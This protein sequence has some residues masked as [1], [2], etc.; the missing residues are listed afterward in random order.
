[1]VCN[2]LFDIGATMGERL[3]Y[4]ASVGFV[5]AVA[6]LLYRGAERLNRNPGKW[7][8]AGSMTVIV[9][10]SAIKTIS[11]NLDWKNDE[12]LFF[13]DVKV[14]PNSFLV[15][16]NVATMLVNKAEFEKDEQAK[17]LDLQ[18][19]LKLFTKVI[20]MQEHY[21]LGYM[22]RSVAYYKLGMTDS[23][24]AD[25]DTVRAIYY[26]H[27]QLPEMYYH[28]GEQYM[29]EGKY[30]QASN[31]LQISLKLYPRSPEARA[32]LKAANDSLGAHK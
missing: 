29:T 19:G 21:V 26:V 5:I 12:T 7:A 1:M 30:I 25:L 23:M 27:P 14:S 4:H 20:G 18:R 17:R 16:A 10:L 32:A 3:I 13:R 28:A 8:L 31:A 24:M 15:N 2:V 9:T 22:N 11:R 6:Y